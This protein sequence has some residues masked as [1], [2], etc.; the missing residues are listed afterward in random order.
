[1]KLI[2]LLLIAAISSLTLYA[3]DSKSEKQ[4][5]GVELSEWIVKPSKVTV[6]SGDVIFKASNKGTLPHELV[7][8][9]TGMDVKALPVEEGKVVEAKAGELIGEIEPDRLVPGVSSED[10]FALG[11]G[12]YALI[13]NIAGHYQNGMYAALEVK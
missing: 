8:V 13:C 12:Q 9:K 7:I 4:T 10:T 5:V 6:Q 3:C 1:M 2:A 11:V